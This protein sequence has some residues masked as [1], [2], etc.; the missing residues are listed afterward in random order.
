VAVHKTLPNVWLRSCWL[1]TTKCPFVPLQL[2][3]AFD[4]IKDDKLQEDQ[5]AQDRKEVIFIAEDNSRH[6]GGSVESYNGVST[7][8]MNPYK[9]QLQELREVMKNENNRLKNQDS[10]LTNQ[11]IL[12]VLKELE[13]AMGPNNQVLHWPANPVRLS[14]FKHSFLSLP[15]SSFPRSVST[16]PSP[17]CWGGQASLIVFHSKLLICW[18][19]QQYERP[20]VAKRL[21]E[22]NFFPSVSL[23]EVKEV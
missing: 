12:T 7:G 6:G 16:L 19:H 5:V 23:E 17:R 2:A 9:R 18:W 11:H 1:S 3:L 15:P 21:L 13:D 14:H 22:I 20:G 8:M 10:H 4:I